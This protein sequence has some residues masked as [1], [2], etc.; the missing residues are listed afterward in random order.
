MLHYAKH[1]P[2]AGIV[3]AIMM[4]AAFGW[5]KA[6]TAERLAIIACLCLF[7]YTTTCGRKACCGHAA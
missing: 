7:A 5:A 6:D 4:A 1:L 2:A 3:L